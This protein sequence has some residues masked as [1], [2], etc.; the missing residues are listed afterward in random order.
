MTHR[1]ITAIVTGGAA[2]I[3]RELVVALLEAGA[4]VLAA[5]AD[6]A[7][8]K[9]LAMANTRHGSRLACIALDL[10][11]ADGTQRVVAHALSVFGTFNTLISNAGIGRM[12]YTRDLLD[13]PPRV[14][15][16]ADSM[17]QRFFEVNAMAAIR[18][19]NAAVP[20]LLAQEWGRIVTVTT[21]LDSMLNAGTGP[22]GPSKAALEAYS[23][24]ISN[25]LAGTGV[26]VNV[27]V[28]GGAV[29][30]AMIPPQRGLARNAL[31]PPNVM[32]SPL[33]WLLSH[34]ADRLNGRRIR[35]NCWDPEK[36]VAQCLEAAC[37]PVAWSSLAAG[38]RRE[39]VR[40]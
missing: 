5:D 33:L 2:G 11:D 40:T 26:T 20:T 10:T 23:A 8:L 35:A 32:V 3:G 29:D 19:V 22:Y 34:D 27:L 39:P 12:L 31:L 18:L 1:H 9:A 17:W 4:R 7:Q 21:S 37:A 36:P 24:V 30:T 6:S 28:P 13:N 16:I 15:E 38:Q 25:E 14:W